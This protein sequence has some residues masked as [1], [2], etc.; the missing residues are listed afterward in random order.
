MNTTEV[1]LES[2]NLIPSTKG[3]YVSDQGIR[4]KMVNGEAMLNADDLYRNI[5]QA[6]EKMPKQTGGMVEQARE[7]REVVAELLHG[8]G[9]AVED[10][11][12]TSK[13]HLEVIRQT[14]FSVVKEAA[15]MTKSL[16]D[17][18]KFFL[19]SEHDK[20]IAKLKDFIHVCEQLK[21]LKDSG[22]LDTVADTIL[23]L[24]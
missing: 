1:T 8:L 5:V 10:F 13:A 23:K 22:F 24:A 12:A 18:R 19:D 11:K 14:R 6:I 2:K 17:L 3:E 21:A 15:D 9:G 20:E 16:S 4:V 7:A